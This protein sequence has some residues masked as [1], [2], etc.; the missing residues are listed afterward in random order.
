MTG[1]KYI[2]VSQEFLDLDINTRNCQTEES[3]EDCK[4][5]KYHGEII[6]QCGCLPFSFKHLVDIT[7]RR[8]F[9]FVKEIN[10][11]F[12]VATCS[13]LQLD[14]VSDISHEEDSCLKECEGLV[15]DIT[16]ADNSE[17]EVEREL[18]ELYEDYERFKTRNISRLEY[19]GNMQGKPHIISTSSDLIH[20]EDLEFKTNLEFIRIYFDSSMF[21][22]ISKVKSSKFYIINDF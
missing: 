7:V 5:R 18:A 16:K 10:I 22:K 15:V 3:L 9:Y 20:L 14:C 11:L 21:E 4:N 8:D 6:A 12:Q 19:S 17:G 2:S 13:P 1:V